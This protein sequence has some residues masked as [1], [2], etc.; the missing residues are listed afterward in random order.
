MK[1]RTGIDLCEISRMMRYADD[2][3]NAFIVRCFTD[4][5]REYVESIQ[6]SK[7]R[8]ESYAAR[9]AAKEAAA[10]ALGTG[11]CTKG[12]GFTDIEI[13]KD[14]LGAPAIVFAGAALDRAKQIQVLSSAISITHEKDYAAAAVTLLT[15]EKDF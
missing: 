14:E 3:D 11:I 10:K 12:I 9:Y 4:K 8:A 7:R 13:I 6:S 5:E 1:V 2:P 15:D